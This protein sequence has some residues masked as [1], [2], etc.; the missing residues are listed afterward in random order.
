M[1]NKI[2]HARQDCAIGFGSKNF[3]RAREA[4]ASAGVFGQ[5]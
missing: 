3:A 2:V 1:R 5:V 4:S